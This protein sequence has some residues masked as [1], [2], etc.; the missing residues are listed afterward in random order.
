MPANAQ[1]EIDKKKNY[2]WVLLYLICMI[3]FTAIGLLLFS[4]KEPV[5]SILHRSELFYPRMIW[6]ETLFTIGYFFGFI[7]P[8]IQLFKFRKYV[9]GGYIAIAATIL[10]STIL[11]II[12]LFVSIFFPRSRFFDTLPI[13]I[14]IG[15]FLFCLAKICFLKFAQAGQLDKLNEVPI[16]L[17]TP[18]QLLAM[19]SICEQQ[20]IIIDKFSK[21]I[22]KIREKIQ[23]S[24]PQRG[25]IATSSSYREMAL[26]LEKFYDDLMNGQY[27]EIQTQLAKIEQGIIRVVADCKY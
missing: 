15:I 9:G 5:D 22:K 26:L 23:Y 19:L 21:H 17:K 20:P 3:G 14:Q 16:N 27:E 6:F 12:I 7:E 25:K 10:N 18:E 2:I 1:N 13:I 24:I 4:D 8:I 11:S